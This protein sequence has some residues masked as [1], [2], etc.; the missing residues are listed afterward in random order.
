MRRRDVDFIVIHAGQQPV[1][2]TK[3]S[4]TPEDKE[5]AFHYFLSAG[6]NLH[7]LKPELRNSGLG[8]QTAQKCLCIC[9]EGKPDKNGQPSQTPTRLQQES[10]FDLVVELT[11]RYPT[12][13]VVGIEDFGG[14]PSEEQAFNVRQWLGNYVPALDI[15]A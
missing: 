4:N 9:V 14:I 13:K 3:Y 12:A 11:E 15:A 1:A 6:A 8:F 5:N 2:N 10:L 7:R